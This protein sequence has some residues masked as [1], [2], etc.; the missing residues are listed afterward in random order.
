MRA[1]G[2]RSKG[3]GARGNSARSR[4]ERPLRSDAKQNRA[5]L[6]AA[7][8]HIVSESGPEALTVSGVARRAGLNRSTAYQHFRDREQLL[9]AVGNEFAR[10]LHRMFNEPRDFG[11][12]V[13]FFVDYFQEQPDIARIWLFRLLS[14]ESVGGRGWKSY[15][16]AFERLAQSPRSQAGI[17]AEMLAAIAMTSAMVWSL[18]SRGRSSSRRA[19]RAETSRFARE[20]KRLFLH[21][22]L[23]PEAWPSLAEEIDAGKARS[24]R[25]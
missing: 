21:G 14:G 24:R 25:R 1:R 10:D 2:I 20:F 8:R 18:M 7:A 11:G 16:A 13:D 5:R 22:A 23:R 17:D 4:R 3:A 9:D 12:Q 15:V 6:L 19:Q